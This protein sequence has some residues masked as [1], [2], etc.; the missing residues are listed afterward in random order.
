MS[1][2]GFRNYWEEIYISHGDTRQVG[3]MLIW[4]LGLSFEMYLDWGH[5]R[6]LYGSIRIQNTGILSASCVSGYKYW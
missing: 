2:E 6:L 3:D 1:W 4:M 5:V